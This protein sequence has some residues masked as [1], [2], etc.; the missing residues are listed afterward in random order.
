MTAAT[1]AMAMSAQSVTVGHVDPTLANDFAGGCEIDLNNDGFMEAIISGKP[2]WDAAPGRI[3][4]DAE[5]NE[6]QSDL[7][8][9]TLTW[10]GTSYTAKEFA[11]LCGLRSHIIPADFNGDGNI[12]LFIAGEAYDY[13]GVYL[14]D[15]SGNFARDAR[16]AVKDAEGNVVP[17]HPRAVD[18]ADF[19]LD[20]RPDFVSI[21]WSAVEGNRQAN[22]GVLI[23][24]GDG[25]FRNV[26]ETGTIGDGA[27][28]Y[29]MALCT[30]KAYDLNKDGYP[31]IL[32]QGNVD[33]TDQAPVYTAAGKEVG[34][35]L[36]G[37]QSMGVDDNGNVAFFSMELGTGVSHQMGN[38]NFAVADFNNDG[39]P[40]VFLTGES[41]DDARPAGAWEYFPQLLMGKVS[42]DNELTYTDNASFVGRAKDIRPLNSNNM[43]VRAIDYNGD[44]FYDLFYDGWCTQML[45]GS[46]STQAGYLFNGSAAGLTS[47]T[48][49][50]GASEMG[51]FFLD[52]GVQGALNYAF[53]GYHGDNTYFD[54]ATDN[55][56]GRSLVFT[57]NPYAKAKRPEAP[58]SLTQE[59]NDHSV[60]LGWEPAASSMKNVTYAYYL[61]EKTTGR[62]LNSVLAF[63]GGD[64]DGVRKALREGNA[65]MNTGISLSNV[66]DGTYEWGVQTVSAALQ[67]SSFAKGE[68]VVVGSGKPDATAISEVGKDTTAKEIARYNVSGQL[69]QQG[70]KGI[71]IVKMSDGTVQK[72]IVK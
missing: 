46:A 34:R 8:S 38:G 31:D 39:T 63:V 15:G 5:G 19:N 12:D 4:M 71:N 60:T 20:G 10:N 26:M 11:E 51:I 68:T 44:G 59:V 64:K 14:N 56:T 25:T 3:I 72:V 57:N 32:L 33:N 27:L 41:P 65:Y 55:K 9:W 30:V 49:I 17:W 53:T 36:L 6:K 40:D 37:L 28:D 45:D 18:V 21:G 67:G 62:M 2:Q 7:Q 48:R 35:T 61:K 13:S 52:N 1:L 50:P 54:D 69:I 24:Q 23:N 16:Y 66:P 22:C 42:A 43:A 58:V 70:Q 29:E 47:Y